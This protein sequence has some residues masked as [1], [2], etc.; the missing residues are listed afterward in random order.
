MNNNNSWESPLDLSV[1]DCHRIYENP[2]A[3]QNKQTKP[4]K[5]LK[6]SSYWPKKILVWYKILRTCPGIHRS[7][8]A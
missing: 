8:N 4:N 5:N 2:L 3:K 6:V 1:R 7:D